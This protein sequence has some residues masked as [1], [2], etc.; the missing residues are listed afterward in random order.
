[1]ASE[2]SFLL[3]GSIPDAQ[4]W[5]AVSQ[6][7]FRTVADYQ[8]EASRL[9]GTTGARGALRAFL[10]EWMA[11]DRLGTLS[12]LQSVYPTFN[13]AMAAS[14]KEELDRFYD[15]VLWT[16]AGSLRDLL[17]SNVSFVDPTLAGLYGTPAPDAG[18]EPVTLDPGLRAGILSRAGYLALHS[19][20]DSS[21]PIAR[22]VFLMQSILCSP[23]PPPP[24][25]V[26]P[27]PSRIDP[28]VAGFTTRQRFTL[29]A[30]NATCAAC[31]SVIDGFGFGF[32]Q[33]DGLG[34]YRMVENGQLVD[35]SGTITATGDIDGP[36]NGVADLAQKLLLSQRPLECF[37]K[38]AYRYAM[39]QI[40]VPGD[41]LS[42]LRAAFSVDAPMTNVLLSIV[43]DP[44]FV[45]RIFEP[46]GP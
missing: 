16:R 37:T 44:V 43:A 21:G 20:A 32:E 35:S 46:A 38:Q 1:V 24:P 3:T 9:L 4:L 30:L 25:N 29:H 41:D 33:F 19:D 11:T 18:F 40:E 34:A 14:M 27:P 2:L 31:H 13:F 5:A 7:T 39:G 15:D 23:P 42:A 36:F 22:G 6:G 26:P 28:R 8:R 12:K 10:H 17:T 45:T